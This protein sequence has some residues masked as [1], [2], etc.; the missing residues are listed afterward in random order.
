MRRVVQIRGVAAML[1][2][3]MACLAS[4]EVPGILP[5]GFGDEVD[6]GVRQVRTAT[7]P[8]RSVDRAMAAGYTQE[9][10]CVE[11]PP[12]GAMGYHFTRANLRDG[13]LEV[14]KP[15]VL[16]YEKRADGSFKLNG[17]EYIVPLDSWKRSEPPTIMGQPLKRFDPAGFWYLHVWVWEA[18]PSGLFA[19]WNPRVKCP[20][21]AGPKKSE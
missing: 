2:V 17:V 1:L 13:V 4:D 7:A 3:G 11:R 19:D 12:E 14:D 18:S 21:K 8:F 20:K 15:E 9:T 6:R 16:V 10:E 5:S